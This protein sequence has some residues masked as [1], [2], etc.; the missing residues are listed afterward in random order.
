MNPAIQTAAILITICLLSPQAYARTAVPEHG[1][2][3]TQPTESV[4]LRMIRQRQDPE[5][6]PARGYQLDANGDGTVTRAEADAHY[7]W[8]FTVLD[9]N[10]DGVV[11]KA[12]FVDALDLRGRDPAVREAHVERLGVL[13]SRLDTDGDKQVRRSEFLDACNAHFVTIDT[14]GDGLVTVSEF[15]ATRPL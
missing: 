11:G 13:F 4:G 5:E 3:L 12:E 8:L 15:R 10:G 14:D 9:G 2:L 1:A 7:S 6:G